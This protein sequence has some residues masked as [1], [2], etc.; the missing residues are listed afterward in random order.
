MPQHPT[1][2]YPLSAVVGSDDLVLAL[3]LAAVAPEV[4][5]V[6]VRGEKGTAKTTAVRGLAAVLPPV[7]VREGDRFSS[8]PRDPADVSPDADLVATAAVVSRPVRLVELPVGAGEDRVTGSIHLERVL[9]SGRA[10]YE[11][12]LLAKAHR[13]LLYVDE[14]NLLHDHLVDLLLDA[15]ATG[16]PTVER[17]GVSVTHPARFVLVGTMNPEEGE[18]RPQLLDRFGLAVDVAAPRDPARTVA[19]ATPSTA[20]RPTT[21]GS[22][23][24]STRR[25]VLTCNRIRTL[26]R[27]PTVVQAVVQAVAPT[28]AQAVAQAVARTVPGRI[29][30]GSTTQRMPHPGP[31]RSPGPRSSPDPRARPPGRPPPPGTAS[32]PACSRPAA[33]TVA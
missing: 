2:S 12:G 33:P 21:N 16:R 22:S 13:G 31:R 1:L 25:S 14:V 5:G 11:P 28:V 24:P 23:R 18:L 27:A 30:Q 8:D 17:D 9:A 6:L 20:P 15:A 29:P 7:E 32:A 3:L 26:T 4:G 19:V 10:E